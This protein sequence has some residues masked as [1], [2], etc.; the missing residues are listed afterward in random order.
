[1]RE[2]LYEGPDSFYQ[3]YNFGDLSG[4]RDAFLKNIK[5]AYDAGVLIAGGGVVAPLWQRAKSAYGGGRGMFD[6]EVSQAQPV[7]AREAEEVPRS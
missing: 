4:F 1:M 7:Q 6:H 2:N 3:V 5:G